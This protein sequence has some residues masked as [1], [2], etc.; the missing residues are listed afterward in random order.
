M[1]HRFIF[2]SFISFLGIS[3]LILVGGLSS[4]KAEAQEKRLPI[5]EMV[6]RGEVK[7][8]A[9]EKVWKNVEPSYFLVFQGSKIKT[10]KGTAL[11]S[12][13]NNNQIEMGQNSILAFEQ[14]D[15]L[16]LYQGR[17]DFRISPR[18]DTNFRVGN[19]IVVKTPPLQAAQKPALD[20]QKNETAMGSISIHP[21]GSV[22]LRSMQGQF[23]VLN[24][25]HIVLAA[26]SPKESLTIP[27][28]AVEKPPS[29]KT[30]DV[31][32]AQVG[33]VA[34]EEVFEEGF[35]GLSGWTW[36]GI[37]VGVLAVGGI[38]AAAGGGGGG[39]AAAPVCP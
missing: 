24:Q 9:R 21:N 8:E 32:F 1:G 4:F 2:K 28:I 34:E 6:S 33:E 30:P 31:K 12:M 22:S 14:K 26:I 19:L 29:E 7:F 35:L 20:S 18:A 23:A 36:G 37:G 15:R 38:A 25:K 27:S 17:I 13:G 39:E 5:G 3:F 10:E 11:I 16:R